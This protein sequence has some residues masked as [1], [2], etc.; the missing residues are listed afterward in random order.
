M[1]HLAGGETPEGRG[2]A[3]ASHFFE[4]GGKEV[5]GRDTFAERRPGWSAPI[6]AL[7]VRHGASIVFHG[8]DH[9]YAQQERDGVIYQLVPQPGH[10][11]F[12]NTRSALEYGYKSGVI[13]GASGILRVSVSPERSR[14]EYVRAYPDSAEGERQRTG[15]V[16]HAYTVFSRVNH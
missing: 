9:L 11:R 1:H 12:D 16:T 14:V 5:D 13:Q 8:H 7:L 3:E 2:G 10:S 4:W 6:H 15:M